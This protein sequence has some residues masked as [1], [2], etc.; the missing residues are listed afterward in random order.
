M[1]AALNIRWGGTG[2]RAVGAEPFTT[3][4]PTWFAGKGF[5]FLP[6]VHEI[7]AAARGD[8]AGW[9]FISHQSLPQRHLMKVAGYRRARNPQF[10][11]WGRIVSIQ[12][13]LSQIEVADLGLPDFFNHLTPLVE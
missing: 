10:L 4:S 9:I 8:R 11:V 13:A 6:E 5:G 1:S 3:L 12:H 2:S 7:F